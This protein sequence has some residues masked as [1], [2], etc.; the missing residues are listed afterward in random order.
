M[1]QHLLPSQHRGNWNRC[2]AQL[3]QKVLAVAAFDRVSN[4]GSEGP[5]SG[6]ALGHCQAE[7]LGKFQA[8]T[9]GIPEMV[10]AVDA[11]NNPLPVGRTERSHTR[12]SAWAVLCMEAR[13]SC[14]HCPQWSDP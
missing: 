6:A 3:L 8:A 12:A 2:A 14:I 10:L 4:I 13:T 7:V 11:K 9:Q 5:C 1:L